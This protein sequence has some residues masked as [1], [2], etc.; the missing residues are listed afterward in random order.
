LFL[1]NKT[2]NPTIKVLQ[3][4]DDFEL[5]AELSHS[6]IKNFIINQIGKGGKII[7]IYMIYQALMILIGL[8]FITRSLVLALRD[9]LSPLLFTIGGLLITFTLLI[10]IHELLHGLALKLAGARHVTFGA[11]PKKFIFYS[12]AD[13]HVLNRRQFT[14]VALTPLFAVKIISLAAIIMYLNHPFFYL[15]VLIMSA[16]S[17]FCA[18]DI[19]M[20]SFFYYYRDSEIFSYDVKA[21]KKS[22]F[23]RKKII[24]F[25]H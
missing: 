13:R 1:I 17:L 2:K 8:F 3:E 7:K 15:P 25:H 4:N 24:Q 6:Q 16:H 18:G 19:G 11:Y 20:L 14:F 23:Y 21:E 22:Y 9:N 12:E 5:V 10:I